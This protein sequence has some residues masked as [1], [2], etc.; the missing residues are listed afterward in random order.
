LT[1]QKFRERG[2]VVVFPEVERGWRG[3]LHLVRNLT[4]HPDLI[5]SSLRFGIGLA[6]VYRY[7]HEALDLLA[8]LAPTLDQVVYGASC[9]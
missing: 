1:Y 3:W 9:G 5:A 2:V 8:T 6:T 7:V 4:G